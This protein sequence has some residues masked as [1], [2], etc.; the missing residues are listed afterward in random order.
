MSRISTDGTKG[1]AALVEISGADQNLKCDELIPLN[2][3]V[4]EQCTVHM[5]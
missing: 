3:L 5:R 1:S 2:N 4:Y